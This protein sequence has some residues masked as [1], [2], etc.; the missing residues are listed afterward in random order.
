MRFGS[1][2]LR[3]AEQIF[4]IIYWAPYNWCVSILWGRGGRGGSG[5]GR[6]EVME[7]SQSEELSGHGVNQNQKKKE[8]KRGK[9]P[10]TLGPPKINTSWNEKYKFQGF[11]ERLL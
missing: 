4:T 9:Q 5:S 3:K 8:T 1:E 10:R 11:H 7:I 6:S 2:L